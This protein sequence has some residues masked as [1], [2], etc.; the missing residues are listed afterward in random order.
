MKYICTTCGTQFQESESVPGSCPIC[1][2]ER[3]YINWNGQQ[4]I[5]LNEMSKKYKNNFQDINENI[6][7]IKTEPKFAI[8]QRALLIKT[9]NGN[10][11]WDC[12]SFIDENTISNIKEIGGISAIAIS[13]P[14]FY[15]SMIEWSIA[16]GNVPIYI[17]LADKEWI[18]NKHKNIVLWEGDLKIL[19]DEIT[20]INCGGHF[21]GSSVMHWAGGNKGKGALFT[22]DTINVG[23][24]QKSVSFMYS[25]PNHIPLSS[26]N[27]KKI[28]KAVK[29]FKFDSIY[30]A[31]DYSNIQ[32]EAKIILHN[33]V[34]RYLKIIN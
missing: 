27:V 20:M 7:S 28:Q 5:T 23:A 12:I 16:F 13:H 18:Q 33:S 1:E 17:H 34:E 2:D 32:H 22:S 31:W 30:G 25:F 14:H 11:L 26:P 24:D 3:Q 4:W 8:G 9:G 19:N 15:S 29:P 6:I 21:P 10:I